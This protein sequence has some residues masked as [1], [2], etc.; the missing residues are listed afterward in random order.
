MASTVTDA[1]DDCVM[2]AARSV[3]SLL[4]L[5]LQPTKV[6]VEYCAVL[7]TRQFDVN[8]P[9]ESLGRQCNSIFTWSCGNHITLHDIDMLQYSRQLRYYFYPLMC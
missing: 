3:T 7:R 9:T 1:T 6:A 5:T 2:R 8:N 4:L